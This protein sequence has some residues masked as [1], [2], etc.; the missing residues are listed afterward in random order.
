MATSET[1]RPDRAV[2]ELG[3]TWPRITVVTCSYN[4]GKF[5][6]ETLLSVINQRYPNL[7]YIVVDGGSTDNSVEIIRKYE[8]H[9][10]WWVSER[11]SGQSDALAKGF[12]KA[13]GEILCWL[14]SDDLLEQ[15]ALVE[16][17]RFFADHDD[18]DVVYGDTIF[19]DESGTITRRYKTF[20][21]SSWLMLNTA[22]YVPQPSTFWR[23]RIYERVGGLD[24]SLHMWLDQD[25]W[26]RFAETTE[27]HHVR[28]YWSRL[29]QYPEIKTLNP[30]WKDITHAERRRI[31]TRYLG[32]RADSIRLATRALAKGI[33][34][35]LKI[36]RGC[37]WA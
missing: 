19:I 24:R 11:D 29:R 14:C 7:E 10:T 30:A 3:V 17:G 9:L 34:V 36:A 31:E 22:N 32:E 8:S 33:R 15:G 20:P 26:L 12:E 13:S 5:L 18:A 23:R 37:Y 35:A 2:G 21:F 28:R 6:E 1:A 16:V 25:L 27:L 4:Q